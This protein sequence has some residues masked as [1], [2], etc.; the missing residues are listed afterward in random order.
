MCKKRESGVYWPGSGQEW[1][2]A[3]HEF[4]RA[5][6]DKDAS[7]ELARGGGS[8]RSLWESRETTLLNRKDKHKLLHLSSRFTAPSIFFLCVL[9]GAEAG[10]EETHL[11]SPRPRRGS[12]QLTPETPLILPQNLLQGRVLRGLRHAQTRGPG[13]GVT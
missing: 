5:S 8:G 12:A 4:L 11:G 9:A 1:G 13:M 2:R 3:T 10:C 7:V 6:G